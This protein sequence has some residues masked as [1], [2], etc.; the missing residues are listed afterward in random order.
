MA[1]LFDIMYSNVYLSIGAASVAL[2]TMVLLRLP[3]SWEPLFVSFS[4]T[5]F[6]YNLNRRT[7]VKEDTVNCPQRADFVRRHGRSLFALS[8]GSYAT[9]LVLAF[10]SG[11]SMFI[12]A[13]LLMLIVILYSVF[14]MKRIFLVKDITVAIGWTV[15]PLMTAS[16][17]GILSGHILA[18]VAAFVFLRVLITTVVFDVKDVKGDTLYGIGTIPGR[19]GLRATKHVLYAANGACLLLIL[20]MWAQAV[21]PLLICLIPVVVLYSCFY[22]GMLHR[23][24]VEMVSY[25]LADGEFVL[26]GVLT[27]GA[28]AFGF[29]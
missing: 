22:I 28:L 6:L 4:C 20:W 2:M 3:L 23:P 7:D 17:Y 12:F 9:A 15:I 14:R 10:I 8:A 24:D 13:I 19:H 11:L 18:Y 5:F 27:L 1:T 21:F 16:F 25:V 26:M 29:V